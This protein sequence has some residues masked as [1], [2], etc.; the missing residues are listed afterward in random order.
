[1]IITIT[2]ICERIVVSLVEKLNQIK[3]Y[4]NYTELNFSKFN[5]TKFNYTK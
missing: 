4:K 5:Y 2:A 1:M 3:L